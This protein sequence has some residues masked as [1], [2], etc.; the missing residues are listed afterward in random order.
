MCNI[1]T[2]AINEKG[3]LVK[4]FVEKN[5]LNKIADQLNIGVPTLEDIVENIVKPGRDPRED[6]PKP[7][8]RSD[9]LKIED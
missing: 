2:T 4:Q 1:S 5:G 9:V 8:L 6:M 7:I 3:L